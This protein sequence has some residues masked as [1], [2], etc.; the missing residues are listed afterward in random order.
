M[1][2]IA[3]RKIIQFGVTDHPNRLFLKNQFIEFEYTHP[4]TTLIHDNSGEFRFFPYQDYSFNH[5]SILPYCP[6]MNAYAERFVRSLRQECLDHFII[7]SFRQ[8]RNLV[9]NYILYYNNY[10]PHQGINAIPNRPVPI[11]NTIGKI[12][13]QPVLFGLH[14]HYFRDAA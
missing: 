12:R 1:I 8:L 13:K 4:G 6:N 2:E 7:F 11:S 5:V 14:N 3:S 9:S 10:R